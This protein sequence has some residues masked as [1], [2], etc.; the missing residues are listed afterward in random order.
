M[1]RI[2]RAVVAIVLLVLVAG[3]CKK[4]RSP[5]EPLRLGAFPNVTHA[6][7]LVGNADGTLER[8][9][10]PGGVEVKLFNAGPAAMEA[11]LS[12][13]IDAAYV[14]TGPAVNAYLKGGRELR[15]IASASDGGAMLV[16]RSARTPE[17]L[18]GKKI[19]VPQAGN[20][21]DIALR[22]WLRQHNLKV[23]KGGVEVVSVANPE[24]VSLFARGEI[25]GAWVPEPWGTRMLAEGGYVLVDERDLWPGRRFPTTLL[26]TTTRALKERRPQL[27]ALMRAHVELTRRWQADPE[28]FARQLNDG[29][30]KA[31]TRRLDEAVVRDAF[32][33]LGPDLYP[34]QRALEIAAAHAQAVGYLRDAD[35]SGM[36][37][38][39][40]LEAV[41]GARAPPA[42]TDPHQRTQP[43]RE[44]DR[45]RE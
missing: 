29:F 33:R 18:R 24:V 14:G 11:L 44:G 28:A 3:G 6:Q 13:S 43:G 2:T 35:V 39:S 1:Q 17:A 32:T 10:G 27:E 4:H 21:Q 16:T 38:F 42:A 22:Y 26:V 45:G 5:S 40:V 25:E 30:E 34:S 31:T 23:G 12:G 8:Y 9:A 19:A 7:A 20:T 36:I 37:D 41:E 15:V